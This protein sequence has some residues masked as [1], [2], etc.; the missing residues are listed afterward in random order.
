VPNWPWEEALPRNYLRDRVYWR[1]VVDVFARLIAG[2]L[3]MKAQRMDDPTSPSEV[4]KPNLYRNP[5]MVLRPHA[6]EGGW[7]RAENW[8]GNE[9][10]PGLRYWQLTLWPA[11]AGET[12]HPIA[13][14][15]AMEEALSTASEGQPA[16][17][18]IFAETESDQPASPEPDTVQD[19]LNPNEKPPH[20]PRY[21]DKDKDYTQAINA[22]LD[23]CFESFAGQLGGTIPPRMLR[24]SR[25][26][27]W[28]R[29]NRKADTT[30]KAIL[31]RFNEKSEYHGAVGKRRNA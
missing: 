5:F 12:E 16:S 24:D 30:D 15:Q 13:P 6:P 1:I 8:R 9:P 23:A 11:E 27:H 7:F 22:D 20:L 4:V 10:P 18:E 26:R 3:V 28:L 21:T 29:K 25:A 14:G 17:L 19:L 2:D 31:D